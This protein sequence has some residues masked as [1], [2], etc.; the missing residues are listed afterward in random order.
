MVTRRLTFG[1]PGLPGAFHRPAVAVGVFDGVHRGHQEV[2]KT[3]EDWARDG[4]DPSPVDTVVVTFSH[5]PRKVIEDAAFRLLTTLEHRLLLLERQRIGG[6]VVLP[7]DEVMAAWPPEDFVRRVLVE[8]LGASRVLVGTNHRFGK[9][10]AGDFALLSSLGERYGFRA[11][12]LPLRCD[13]QVISSTAIRQAVKLGE[14]GT[15]RRLLGREVSVLGRVVEGDRRGRTLGFPT[16]NLDLQHAARP[17]A[18]VYAAR[19]R[20]VGPG[21]GEGPLLPA[22]VN[23]GKRPTFPSEEGEELVEVHLLEGGRDLYGELLEVFFVE[24]LREEQNFSDSAALRAQ[25]AQDV[26]R[27]REI[28]SRK[29]KTGAPPADVS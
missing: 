16:A 1:D 11:R 18:G 9:D 29:T 10:R 8:G 15:A 14:L 23:I 19:A 6:V 4:E 3:L 24:K 12:E 17:P 28:L 26:A 13:G 20:T 25:I 5:H 7:F 27:A 22:A 21:R 2:L